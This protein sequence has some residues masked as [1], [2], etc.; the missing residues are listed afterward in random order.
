MRAVSVTSALVCLAVFASASTITSTPSKDATLYQTADGSLANGSGVHIFAG[1]TNGAQLRRALLAFDVASRIPP[2]SQIT[3]AT[4]TLNISQTIS[5]IEPMELHAV[6][7]NWGEGASNAGSARDG[8]GVPSAANDATW[9]HTF[10]PNRFWSRTGGDFDSIAEASGAAGGLGTFSFPSTLS[11][12]ARV[13]KWLDQPATNFGWIILGNETSSATTKRF[14]SREIATST[15]PALTIDFVA[16]PPP[17]GDTNGDGF[18]TTADVFYLINFLFT[19]GP[20]PIGSGDVNADGF[21][22]VSDVFY[23]INFLFAQG[24]A[25]PP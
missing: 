23:L 6:L 20:A 5:G 2:G 16:P 21:V 18:V 7:A 11:T 12:V 10:Y 9:I 13:Q 15:R 24:P 17:R 19:N 14:D 22:G 8:V 25:P 1:K 4:L 3:R